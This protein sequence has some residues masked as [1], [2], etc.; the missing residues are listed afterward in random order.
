MIQSPLVPLSARR[1]KQ[2]V[3]RRSLRGIPLRSRLLA[4]PCLP[5][6]LEEQTRALALLERMREVASVRRVAVVLDVL[7][8]R[9]VRETV[10]V[11]CAEV[12]HDGAEGLF[13]GGV[14]GGR[15]QGAEDGAGEERGGGGGRE[16]DQGRRGI[17]RYERVRVAA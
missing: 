4:V 10:P 2:P 17:E 6:G 16:G 15:S 13:A 8:A 1:L 7:S 5:W 11:L 12:A 14:V 3:L 9:G